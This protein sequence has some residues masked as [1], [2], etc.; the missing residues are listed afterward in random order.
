MLKD[1]KETDVMY[2]IIDIKDNDYFIG[3]FLK[4]E[5]CTYDEFNYTMRVGITAP[6]YLSKLF[7]PYFA[8]GASIINISSSRDRMNQPNTES[9]TAVKGGISALTHAL[10]VTLS[11]EIRVNSISLGW[12]DTSY[13]EYIV[14]YPIQQPVHRVSNPIDITNMVLSPGKISVSMVE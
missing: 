5:T 12:I 1:L 2:G 6:F 7:M 11:G 8:Q 10:P 3:I 4:K 13:K 9:Y 14:A